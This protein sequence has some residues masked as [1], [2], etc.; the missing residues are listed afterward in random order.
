MRR[1][2]TIFRFVTAVAGAAFH[3]VV[4]GDAGVPSGEAGIAE[5]DLRNPHRPAVHW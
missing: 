4:L 2:R 5:R 3:V 1:T